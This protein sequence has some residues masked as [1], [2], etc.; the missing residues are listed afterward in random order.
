MSESIHCAVRFG[1]VLSIRLL[2]LNVEFE[3]SFV[4]AYESFRFIVR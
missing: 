1:A 4:I 3:V 2:T